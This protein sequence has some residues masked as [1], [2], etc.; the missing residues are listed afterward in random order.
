MKKFKNL[1]FLILLNV[2]LASCDFT[3]ERMKNYYILEE[4]SQLKKNSISVELNDTKIFNI[5]YQSLN[6]KNEV[7]LRKLTEECDYEKTGKSCMYCNDKN[8]ICSKCY[9]NFYFSKTSYK[10]SCETCTNHCCNC[11]NKTY[12]EKCYSNYFENEGKCNKCSNGC[13]FCNNS[14]TCNYCYKSFF[15]NEN[16]CIKCPKGC[17]NCDNS[18]ICIECDS[19]YYKNEGKCIKCSENCKLCNNSSTTCTECNYGYYLNLNKCEKCSNECN[20]CINSTYCS[21]CNSGYL[22]N[23]SK[24]CNNCPPNSPYMIYNYSINQYECNSTCPEG[25]RPNSNS[26]CT[27]CQSNT[28]NDTD[29]K[30]QKCPSNCN[31]CDNFSNCTS[32]NNMV[33]ENGECISIISKGCLSWPFYHNETDK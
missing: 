10:T 4:R 23:S 3:N 8:N 29:R 25:K 32:C 5:F 9:N 14:T 31:N 15:K 33:L 17:N 26:Y 2:I 30:C 24:E 27:Y 13:S 28:Y 18:T 12:C 11:A 7:N 21:F 6:D 20:Y 16:K 19:G 1:I 22:F